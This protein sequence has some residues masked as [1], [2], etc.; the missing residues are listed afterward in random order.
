MKLKFASVQTVYQFNIPAELFSF[1]FLE[2]L[3]SLDQIELEF[4]GYP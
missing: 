2:P 3:D 1:L 4:H